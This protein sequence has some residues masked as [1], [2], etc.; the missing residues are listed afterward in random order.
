ML[1]DATGTDTEVARIM[2]RASGMVAEGLHRVFVPAKKSFLGYQ[3]LTTT[4]GLVTARFYLASL[5]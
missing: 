1:L 3:I 2:I 4:R 5:L